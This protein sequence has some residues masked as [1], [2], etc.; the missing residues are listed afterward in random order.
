M[1]DPLAERLKR[2]MQSWR[3]NPLGLLFPSR[4]GTPINPN[5]VVPRKLHPLLDKLGIEQAGFH[6]F[7]H[8]HSSLLVELGA[9]VTV[10]QAQLGHSD[11][12]TTMR[13]YTHVIPQSQREAVD[14]LARVLDSSGLE[15]GP[16]LLN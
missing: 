2:Y 11:L 14:R 13:A 6:A 16:K 3:P 8:S 7:R 9:P 5:H 1:P 4:R 10:A 15:T 12:S